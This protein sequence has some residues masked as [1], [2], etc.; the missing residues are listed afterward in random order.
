[1]T[2]PEPPCAGSCGA[3]LPGGVCC[4]DG[5]SELTFWLLLPEVVGRALL[6]LLRSPYDGGLP[7]AFA[8]GL[9]T[10]YQRVISVRTAARCRFTPTCSQYG[11]T[12]VR[13][14]GVV[15]GVR[16]IAGRLAR[17]RTSVAPGTPDPVPSPA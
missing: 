10:Q 2:E 1:V 7:A 9:I 8:V 11:L 15:R 17:C 6:G 3:C 16:M 5:A 14:F 13:R 4:Q 12:A